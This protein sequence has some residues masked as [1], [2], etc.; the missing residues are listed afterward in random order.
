MTSVDCGIQC[1]CSIVLSDDVI[2]NVLS[3]ENEEECQNLCSEQEKCTY[4]TYYNDN[5]NP[6]NKTFL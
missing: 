2:D 5:A 6:G 4:F 1:S 3:V